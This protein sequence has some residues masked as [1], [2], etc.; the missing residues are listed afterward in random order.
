MGDTGH[1]LLIFNQKFNKCL[2]NNH[3]EQIV[4]IVAFRV[5]GAE[6]S[7]VADLLEV[8]FAGVIFV[9]WIGQGLR[10]EDKVNDPVLVIEK[11]VFR[12][13]DAFLLVGCDAGGHLPHETTESL[14]FGVC[15]TLSLVDGQSDGFEMSM[16]II[17]IGIFLD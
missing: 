7:R 15:G 10:R 13:L 16:N 12:K 17:E 4:H 8:P 14:V 11:Q 9:E 2:K 5:C 3:H 6:Q 1:F